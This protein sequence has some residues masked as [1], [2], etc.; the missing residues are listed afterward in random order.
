MDNP[1]EQNS[2]PELVQT[3]LAEVAQ[4]PPNPQPSPGQATGHPEGVKSRFVFEI[5]NDDT[6]VEEKLVEEKPVEAVAVPADPDPPVSQSNEP[7]KITEIFRPRPMLTAQQRNDEI[8]EQI[9]KTRAANEPVN[10]P[11]Q[12]VAPQMTEQT[13]REMAAGAAQSARHAAARAAQAP[14]TPSPAEVQAAGST[15]IVYRPKDFVPGPTKEWNVPPHEQT[16]KTD[17]QRGVRNL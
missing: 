3:G 16:A 4:T 14:R 13:R 12:P 2:Q 5:T 7:I 10:R 11:P 6:P 8:M 15:T 17:Q 9:A 1:Q